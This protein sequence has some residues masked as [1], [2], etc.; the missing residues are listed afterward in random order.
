MHKHLLTWFSIHRE[1]LPWRQDRDPY[2]V[3]LSEIMLQQTQVVTV[4]PYYQ[5]FLAAYPTVHDLAGASLDDILKLWEGLGYYS[6]ARN[7]HRAAQVV[8]Q[9]H[10]GKFPSTVAGL[11]SL[12]GIGPYTAGAIASIAFGLDAPVV[13]G[14]VIRVLARWFDLADDVT[15]T[16]TKK[17]LWQRAE[18]LLPSGK[19]GDWNEAL[20]Q[21]GQQ[22]CTPKQP[23]CTN[24]PVKTWC[25]AHQAGTQLER[26]I[27]K[28]KA[29]TPHYDVAAGVIRRG[30]DEILIAQ[31]PL[32][33]ML[34]GLWEFPG[35]KREAGESLEACLVREVQE[36]LGIQISVEQQLATI[37]HAY[38]H[39]KI[40]LYA[41]ECR[42]LSGEPQ[43]IG[44]ADWTW[45]TLESLDQFAFPVTDQQIITTLRSGGGQLAMDLPPHT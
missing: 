1:D 24:C 4:I 8:V 16:K 26:P 36:E 40:T 13:D 35:G 14:N 28:R 11:Q 22:I 17:D 7:L 2:R 27:K 12:P 15:Q 18:S 3:W 29:P 6:R 20:M 44:C 21:L 5:R 39:F 37:K 45:T 41:F 42:Y 30:A 38:T 32:D 31:R 23:D 33:G 9:E 43:A 25:K 34:G 10:H 19:A